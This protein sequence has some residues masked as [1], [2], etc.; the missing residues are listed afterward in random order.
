MILR[1]T[2][3]EAC[4]GF[5]GSYVFT[6]GEWH[7]WD[8]DAGL[9]S[10]VAVPWLSIDIHDSDF[11]TIRFA[12]PHGASGVAY[13]GITPRIYF[14][15]ES[16]SASTDPFTEASGLSR[17]AHDL[18]SSEVEDSDRVSAM[19]ALLA[20]DEDPDEAA[21]EVDDSEIF[22]ELKTAKFLRLIGLPLPDDLAEIER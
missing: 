2:S 10:S 1:Y 21:G 17:W 5:F 19:Q 9:P 13:L 22:V 15:D 4:M 18:A 14:G 11:T 20:T 12:P 7:T 8:P 3:A 16:A 6:R